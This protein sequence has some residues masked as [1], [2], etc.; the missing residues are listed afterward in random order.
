MTF[1][2]AMG[3]LQGLGREQVRTLVHAELPAP[4]AER[5]DAMTRTSVSSEV[6]RIAAAQALARYRGRTLL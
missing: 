4:Q 3:L 6:I 1:D 2:E 5:L